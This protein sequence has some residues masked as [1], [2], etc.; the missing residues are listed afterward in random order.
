MSEII[1]LWSDKVG[2]NGILSMNLHQYQAFVNQRK[3]KDSLEKV[4]IEVVNMVGL[5]INEIN[6]NDHLQSQ[7]EFI[8]GF[9]PKKSF[10]LLEKLKEEGTEILSRKRIEEAMKCKIVTRNCTPFLKIETSYHKLL[11]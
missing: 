7:L 5:D 10:M 4:I 9:G 11:F 8:S 2:E 3:L 6:R 1:S